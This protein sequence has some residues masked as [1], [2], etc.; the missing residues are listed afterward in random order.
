[1]ATAAAPAANAGVMNFNPIRTMAS[2]RSDIGCVR[3]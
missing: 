1:M 3:R 2:F